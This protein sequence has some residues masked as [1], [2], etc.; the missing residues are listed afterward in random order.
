MTDSTVTDDDLRA[1]K[2]RADAATPSPWRSMVE[3]RDHTSCSSFIMTAKD[4]REAM[5][6]S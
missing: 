4:P 3:G 1:I 2:A 5:T 6:S